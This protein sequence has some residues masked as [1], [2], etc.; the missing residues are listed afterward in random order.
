MRAYIYSVLISQA[1]ARLSKVGNSDPA[2]DAQQA[3]ESAFKVLVNEDYSI[4]ID[5][6]RY[7]RVLEHVLS[8]IDFPVGTGIYML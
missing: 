4:V 5:I 1:Q 7:Q 3:F 6:E 2:V 8:K